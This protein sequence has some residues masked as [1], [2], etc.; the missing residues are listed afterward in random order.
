MNLVMTIEK[1]CVIEMKDVENI[2]KEIILQLS[3]FVFQVV[4]L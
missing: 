3:K 4:I 1:K 2:D